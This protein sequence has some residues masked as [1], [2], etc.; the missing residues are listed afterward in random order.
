LLEV[1]VVDFSL[2][3]LILLVEVVPVVLEQV[4]IFL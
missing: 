4:L 3:H 2:H 1:V